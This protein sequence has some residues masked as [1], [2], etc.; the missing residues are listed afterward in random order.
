MKNTFWVV[1]SSYNAYDQYGDYF[2][3]VWK[4]KPTKDQLIK[5]LKISDECAEHLSNGGG[6]RN[7]PYWED[8]WYNLTEVKE[9]KN[10]EN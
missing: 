10:Y 2:I 1:T 4:D 8:S 7:K 5:S 9:G 6:R 3:A